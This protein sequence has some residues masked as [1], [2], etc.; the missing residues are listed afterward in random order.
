MERISIDG[1]NRIMFYGNRVGYVSDSSA[2][3]DPQF[4]NDELKNWLEEK[5]NLSVSW[6]DGV[7]DRLLL[8]GEGMGENAP[9]LKSCRIWQLKPD[10]DITMKFI[11]FDELTKRFGNPDIENYNMVFDGELD[12]NNLE[13]IYTKFNVNQPIGFSGHSLSMSDIVELYDTN[14]NGVDM[15]SEFHYVDHFGFKEITFE[16]PTQEQFMSM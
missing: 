10:V 12:T 11:G 2:V 13:E 5:Q 4:K 16:P 9:M 7:Y 15:S 3:V 6:K 14:T 1:K 8:G